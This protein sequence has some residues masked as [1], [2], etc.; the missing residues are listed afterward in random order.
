MSKKEA[1]QVFEDRKIRSL[2][3]DETEGLVFFHC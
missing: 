3:D 2:W 1:I